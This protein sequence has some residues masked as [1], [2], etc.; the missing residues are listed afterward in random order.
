MGVNPAAVLD[1][2][3]KYADV[4]GSAAELATADM[5]VIEPSGAS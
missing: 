2:V 5:I 3:A 4:T 1:P